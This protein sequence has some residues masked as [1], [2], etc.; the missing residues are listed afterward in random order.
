MDNEYTPRLKELIED[1]QWSE[2]REKLELLLQYADQMPAPPEGFSWTPAEMES[3][4]ECMT[5]IHIHASFEEGQMRFFFD[6]PSEIANCAWFCR[7][8]GRGIER[9]FTRANPEY[10]E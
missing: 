6:V 2:G 4:P 7:A 8:D 1:F 10:A 3:V 5:P 9:R